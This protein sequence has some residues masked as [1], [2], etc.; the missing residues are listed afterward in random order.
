MNPRCLIRHD[1]R[2]E[3]THRDPFTVRRVCIAKDCGSKGPTVSTKLRIQTT[4][5]C[6]FCFQAAGTW[7][8]Y[9]DGT[10]ACLKC[11]IRA[12]EKAG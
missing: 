2:W 5:K 1:Y 12:K 8:T 4:A 6:N 3:I 9:A 10:I 7:R 11:V